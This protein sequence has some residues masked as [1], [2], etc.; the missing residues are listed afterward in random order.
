MSND[1]NEIKIYK[2]KA[3]GIAAQTPYHPD[4]PARFRALG[5]KWHADAGVWTFD[6]R[7]EARVRAVVEE[8]FGAVEPSGRKVTLRYRL[9]GRYVQNPLRLA[10]RVIAERRGRDVAVRLAAGVVVVEGEFPRRA[11]SAKYPEV[12]GS[13]DADVV[14]EIRD[15]DEAVAAKMVAEGAEIVG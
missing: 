6:A 7:D 8:V 12:L 4:L 1:T 15:V 13:G 14:I 2:T 3:G 9:E 10:G 11:G 5:G